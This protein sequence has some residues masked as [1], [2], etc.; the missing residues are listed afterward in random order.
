[1]LSGIMNANRLMAA[2][3]AGLLPFLRE[4]LK[5]GHRFYQNND[6]KRSSKKSIEEKGINWWYAPP[7]SPDCNPIELV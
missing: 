2:Y 3:E 1:M 7:E 4:G 6:P 5:E